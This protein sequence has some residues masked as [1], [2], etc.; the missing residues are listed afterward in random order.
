MFGW[1]GRIGY[2]EAASS[3]RYLAI[4]VLFALGVEEGKFHCLLQKT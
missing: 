4:S 3:G 2:G 1:A